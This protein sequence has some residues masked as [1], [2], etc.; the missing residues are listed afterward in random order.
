M[1]S[2][3]NKKF[4]IDFKLDSHR[5]RECC[6]EKDRALSRLRK[7][8]DKLVM[9]KPKRVN[10]MKSVNLSRAASRISLKRRGENV[11]LQEEQII[12]R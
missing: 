10:N 2:S 5:H 6:L 1:R 12:Y 9:L 4:L 3:S 7:D 8:K 11:D